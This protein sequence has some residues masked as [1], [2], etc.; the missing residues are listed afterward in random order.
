MRARRHISTR[1]RGPRLR[2]RDRLR[3]I[4]G[5]WC[6]DA[7]VERTTQLAPDVRQHSELGA[8]RDGLCRGRDANG[9]SV[10]GDE[11]CGFAAVSR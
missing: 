8:G 9:Y 6:L 10:S 2:G 3:G 1:L 7:G 5:P 4:A 11:W